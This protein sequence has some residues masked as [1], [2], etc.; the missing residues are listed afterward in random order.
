MVGIDIRVYAFFAET[1]AGKHPVEAVQMMSD[2][3][4]FTEKSLKCKEI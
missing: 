2:I 3:I 1:A 4:K